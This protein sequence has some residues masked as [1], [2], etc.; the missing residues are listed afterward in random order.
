MMFNAPTQDAF[1]IKGIML[2]GNLV[3]RVTLDRFWFDV[4]TGQR[5]DVL[6][7]GTPVMG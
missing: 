1:T 4:G 3:P 2:R 7:I 5:A 6:V